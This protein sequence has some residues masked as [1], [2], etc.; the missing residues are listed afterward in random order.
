[1]RIS[2]LKTAALAALTA[3]T[4]FVSFQ[5]SPEDIDIFSV[6]ESGIVARPNILIVLDNSANWTRASQQ[7]PDEP[8][9]GQAEVKAISDAL[10]F[11]TDDVNVGLMEYI[12]AGAQNEQDSGYLRFHIRPMDADNK[13][14]LQ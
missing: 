4:T 2:K 7:W 5:A 8:T 3:A 11:V 14:T 13:A 9:Q 1:M 6:D 12:A 10:A